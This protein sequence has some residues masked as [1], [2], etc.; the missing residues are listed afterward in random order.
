[1]ERR[2]QESQDKLNQRDQALNNEEENT[3]R[4][5]NKDTNGGN[6]A[7]ESSDVTTLDPPVDTAPQ[8]M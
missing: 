8:G 4:D 7:E 2:L 5:T 6:V 1:M 3:N